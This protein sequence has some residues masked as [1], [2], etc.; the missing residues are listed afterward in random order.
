MKVYTLGYQGLDIIT[1]VSILKSSQIGVV[2]D[3]REKAWSR[4]RGFSKF[5][6]RQALSAA[7]IEYIHIPSAGNPSENR[8]SAKTVADCLQRY[9]QF[10]MYNPDCLD[11][12]LTH[13]K[14]AAKASRPACLTCYEQLPDQCHRSVIIEVLVESAP[15]LRPV[16]LCLEIANGS[17]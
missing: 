12:L 10:L 6:L 3:V 16:H 11:E 1:Y 5:A 17:E 14:R 8:K 15:K 2:L 4:K 9:R 13:I 7:G